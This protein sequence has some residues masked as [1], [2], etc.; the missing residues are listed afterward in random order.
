MAA[1]SDACVSVA[2]NNLGDTY[3]CDSPQGLGSELE[4]HMG[5]EKWM[6]YPSIPR[7]ALKD[8]SDACQFIGSEGVIQLWACKGKRPANGINCEEKFIDGE[9]VWACAV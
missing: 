5:E 6:K 9:M 1:S 4:W 3:A 7:A 8:M 2:S